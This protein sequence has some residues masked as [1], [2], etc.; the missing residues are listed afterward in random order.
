M[1][2][3]DNCDYIFRGVGSNPMI[4]IFFHKQIYKGGSLFMA[5]KEFTDVTI[6][7]CEKELHFKRVTNETLTKFSDK[8]EKEYEET[9][10]QFVDEVELLDDKRESLEKKIALKTKQVELLENKT[11]AD[12]KEIDKAFEILEE[13]DKL[14]DELETVKAGLLEYSKNNPA[15]EYSKRVDEL[16]AEKVETLLDGI[17]AK[18]YLSNSDP[19][20]TIK[21]RNLEKYYQLCIVG[22]KKSKIIQ[23]IKDDVAD[24]LESQKE[25]RS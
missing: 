4:S 10:K 20:D 25:L 6:E 8:A 21:A 18:E 3:K 19:V 1:K 15:K 2:R 22:E 5:K 11:D 9:V 7:M 23:E 14:E 13:I 12:D 17:T 16:L 24:F